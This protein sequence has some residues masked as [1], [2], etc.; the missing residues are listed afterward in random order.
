MKNIW[1]LSIFYMLHCNQNGK[2][3]HTPNVN[4]KG[5]RVKYIQS[6]AQ[7]LSLVDIFFMYFLL[8]K[9]HLCPVFPEQFI[10]MLDA[11]CYCCCLIW[12][13]CRLLS[14]CVS[15]TLHKHIFLALLI[16][17]VYSLAPFMSKQNILIKCANGMCGHGKENEWDERWWGRGWIPCSTHDNPYL[18]RILSAKR[19]DQYALKIFSLALFAF[20]VFKFL[21]SPIPMQC[22]CVYVYV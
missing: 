5:R 22:E 16:Q 14:W 12:C 1:W 21:F 10:W 17:F 13:Y 7:C 4:W 20:F 2:K 18:V 15:N 3:T 6:K 11:A 9:S 8:A 19:S